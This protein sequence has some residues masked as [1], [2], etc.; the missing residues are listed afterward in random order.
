LIGRMRWEHKDEESGND[1]WCHY[2]EVSKNMS[3][4][5]VLVSPVL[6]IWAS[7]DIWFDDVVIREITKR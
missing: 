7:G 1:T 3:S 5:Q 4:D 6:D 2:E